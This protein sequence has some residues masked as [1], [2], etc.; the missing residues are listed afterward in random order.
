MQ[1]ETIGD[2]FMCVGGCPDHCSPQD[3]AFRVARM[4]LDMIQWTRG[5]TSS[6]GRKIQIRVG[7]YTGDVTAAGGRWC[8]R[9]VMV[10]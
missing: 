9:E 10:H 8:L 4:A 5:F 7:I 6:D 1:V 2:A 3:S